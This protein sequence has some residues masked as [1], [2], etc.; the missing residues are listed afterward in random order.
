MEKGKLV[1]SECGDGGREGN[2]FHYIQW[3]S[4]RQGSR[5]GRGSGS[6][7]LEEGRL[8]LTQISSLS[9]DAQCVFKEETDR[10]YSS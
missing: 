9:L 4:Y 7:M 5:G 2:H 3:D 6:E 1:L 8:T 10:V